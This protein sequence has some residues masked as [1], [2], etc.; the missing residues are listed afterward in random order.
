MNTTADSPGSP[1]SEK[2]GER[3]PARSVITPKYW[4]KL[5][6]RLMGNMSFKSHQMV[7]PAFGRADFELL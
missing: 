7:F 6:K 1:M 4:R 5:T 3:Y 2:V